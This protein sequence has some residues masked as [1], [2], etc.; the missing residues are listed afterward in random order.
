M[1]T[2][3]TICKIDNQWEFALWLRKLKQWLCIKL[4]GW[5]REGDG[6]KFK[7]EGDIYIY[8]PIANSC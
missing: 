1:E 7:K 2:Y 3:I 8:I 4:E 5:V 6:T